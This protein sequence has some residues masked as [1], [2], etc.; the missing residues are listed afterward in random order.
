MNLKVHG[1]GGLIGSILTA[2]FADKDV[3]TM[4]GDD[5]IAGGWINQNVNN[6]FIN[7]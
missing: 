7:I 4:S 3:V 5:P 2:I 1:M 6:L